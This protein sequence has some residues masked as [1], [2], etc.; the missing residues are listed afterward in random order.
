MLGTGAE[1]AFL[2]LLATGPLRGDA[3]QAGIAMAIVGAASGLLIVHGGR[4]GDIYGRRPAVL[5]GAGLSAAGLVGYAAAG[6]YGVVLIS[7][8]LRAVGSALAWPALI[9]VLAD[10]APL[11]SRGFVM[12]IF[13]EYESVGLALGPLIGGFVAG[14]FGFGAAFG[15]M[16][17]CVTLAGLVALTMGGRGYAPD[18]IRLI[19]SNEANGEEGGET[20][21]G[22][23]GA[24]DD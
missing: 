16:A 23:P 7:A 5:M 15:A 10:A 18:A 22:G 6:A 21:T 19:S 9:A 8:A 11:E 17:S 12:A 13:G 14:R 20:G 24:P 4:L 3:V 2:P 1:T